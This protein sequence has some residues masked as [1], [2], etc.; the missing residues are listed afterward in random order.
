MQKIAAALCA[1]AAFSW[2]AQAQTL[3]TYPS[4]PLSKF[5]DSLGINI[6][7]EYT[8]GKYA[9]SN[10]VV[11]DLSYISI[12]NV[13]DYI[14][15]PQTWPP[16][17]VQHLE[18][19]AT[20]GVHFNFIGDCNSSFSYAMQELDALVT[21]YPGIA[22]SVEGPNEI[23]NFP[24]YAGSGTNQQQA[25]TFQKE[26]Y[27]YVHGDSKLKGIPVLYMTGAAPVDPATT[28]GLADVA[29]THPYVYGETQP[30]AR[31]L[32]D[33]PVYFPNLPASFP[34]QIT[35]TGYF[36][37][38]TAADGVD[39]NAQA[40]YLANLYFDSALE[41]N[42]RT[43][44]YQLLD[45]Y[46]DTSSD[47]NYGIFNFDGS[48]K[49]SAV[50]LHNLAMLLHPD[51]ASAQKVVQ[52]IVSTLPATAKTLVLTKSDGTIYFFMWNEQNIWNAQTHSSS[53]L[54]SVGVKVKIA[55][56]WNVNFISLLSE[57]PVEMNLPQN[58]DGSYTALLLDSPTALA[59]HPAK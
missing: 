48:P 23:N 12:H 55:G 11:Q 20:S 34:R 41:G 47:N 9:N 38:P 1:L 49:M 57:S 37:L 6:H 51:V 50:L 43:Y 46:N 22:L 10:Q 31:L 21:E 32:S 58:A 25:T 13:R 17:A 16:G 52:A 45:A 8:D 44:V 59:F 54:P 36:T 19:L 3:K 30:Y 39:Q 42:T 29:N 35:E 40:V 18:Q 15:D 26:L 4:M 7:I 56:K 33:F 2:A 53:N 5:Q 27:A 24:C 14:P 28:P